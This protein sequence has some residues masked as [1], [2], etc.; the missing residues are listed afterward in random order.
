[1]RILAGVALAAS[2]F[3]PAIGQHIAPR[4]SGLP[5]TFVWQNEPVHWKIDHGDILTLAAGKKTDWFAWPGGGYKADASPRLLFRMADDFI[6]SAKVT[7][8]GQSTY[9]AGCLALFGTPSVWAKFCLEAQD[10]NRLAVVSVVTRDLSD[11]VTSFS[12]E[13][14]S[15]YLKMAKADRAI[16]LYASADGKNWTIV[17]KFNLESPTGFL[18]GFS[19]QSPDG[20]GATA[21]FED[22]QYLPERVDLWK[23][24]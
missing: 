22:I 6:I 14:R 7:T 5:E 18:A 16:M 20:Q 21:I 10:D 24:N 17:R 19:A 2:C 23:L 11:D 9:D 8:V 13:G 1:L 4:L 3:S 15:A 12:V